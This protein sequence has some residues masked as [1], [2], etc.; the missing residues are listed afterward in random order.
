MTLVEARE[1]ITQGSSP[2]S[3]QHK[4]QTSLLGHAKATLSPTVA[5]A[6]C[7]NL[8]LTLSEH[9]IITLAARLVCISEGRVPV[10]NHRGVHLHKIQSFRQQSLLQKAVPYYSFWTFYPYPRFYFGIVV[11]NLG[12]VEAYRAT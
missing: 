4:L 9:V 10:E 1:L 8:K 12:Y 7:V 2:P 11:C 5:Y 6:H 3:F